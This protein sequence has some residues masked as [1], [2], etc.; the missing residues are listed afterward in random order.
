MRLRFAEA[1]R[2]GLGGGYDTYEYLDIFHMV[3]DSQFV[4]FEERTMSL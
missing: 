1:T 3:F 4:L 2:A